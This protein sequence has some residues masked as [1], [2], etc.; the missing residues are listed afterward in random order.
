MVSK[1]EWMKLWRILMAKKYKKR[2]KLTKDGAELDLLK[3]GQKPNPNGSYN[4]SQEALEELC[5]ELEE[6]L[7]K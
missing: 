2:V 1:L 5:K 6:M 3:R 7:F 4:V